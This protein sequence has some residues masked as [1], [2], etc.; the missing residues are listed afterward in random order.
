LEVRFEGD[1][2]SFFYQCVDF[3]YTPP[4]AEPSAA[5]LLAPSIAFVFLAIMKLFM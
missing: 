5:A 1:D 3:K 4:P 2:L